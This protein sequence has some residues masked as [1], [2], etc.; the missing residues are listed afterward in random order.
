MFPSKLLVIFVG[1]LFSLASWTPAL[2]WTQKQQTYLIKKHKKFDEHTAW[3]NK[4]Y[5]IL[6]KKQPMQTILNFFLTWR[7]L[8][9]DIIVYASHFL[10]VSFKI[11][12]HLC[13]LFNLHDLINSVVVVGIEMICYLC[14][15]DDL[16]R[17]LSTLMNTQLKAKQYFETKRKKNLN[18]T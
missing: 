8:S 2:L 9:T 7:F 18:N 15:K 13:R 4:L 6:L 16:K 12:R 14:H 3:K 5:C 10:D 11:A 1:Y 17:F